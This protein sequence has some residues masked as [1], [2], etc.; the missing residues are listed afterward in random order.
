[1]LAGVTLITH[2][3]SSDVNSWVTA[4]AEAVRVRPGL[5]LDQ[6]RYR[7]DVTDVGHDGGPLTVT[8]TRLS[9]PAPASCTNSPEI[10]VLLNWSDVAGSL[11]F[12]GYHRST[13]DVAAA[14][15]EQLVVPNFLPDLPT[16]VAEL[17]LHLI[18]HSRGASLV[19]ELAKDLGAKGIWVD[20]VTTLDPHP[21]DGVREP[22]GGLNYGDAAMTGWRNV[23]FWD[24]YWR[25]QVSNPLDFTGETI[26]NVH[27]LQLNEAVL[28]SGGYSYEH[29]DV[30]L[31][32]HGTI[33]TS[34]GASDGDASVPAS[35]YGGQHPARD[36]SGYYYSRLL[37]GTRT[38]AGL[39]Q[40][41][42]GAAVR[43]DLNWAGA[44]WPNL[45]CT[46]LDVPDSHV[47]PGDLVRVAYWRQDYD[48][49]ATV[50]FYLDPD[51][52]PYNG[53]EIEAAQQSVSQTGAAPVAGALDIPT[54]SP[55][56]VLGRS[57][58]VSARLS[59]GP[60]TRYDYAPG[61]ITIT[62]RIVG[63]AADDSIRVAGSAVP[64]MAEVFVNNP[65][66]TPTYQADLSALTQWELVGGAGND[67]LVVDFSRRT[68]LPA[69]G[70]AA[71]GGANTTGDSLRITGTTGADRVRI[72]ATQ[73]LVTGESAIEWR[74]I[75]FFG[76]DLGE[77]ADHLVLDG[78][79][80]RTG[81]PNAISDNTAVTVNSGELDLGGATETVD[82]ITVIGG[83]VVN[84]TLWSNSRTVQGGVVSANLSGPGG[85]TMSG[86]GVVA[87]SGTNDY[88]D[89][90][91][92]LSG[93]L[94]VG[95]AVTLPAGRSVNIGA[96]ATVELAAGLCLASRFG[97]PVPAQPVA[98]SAS[99]QVTTTTAIGQPSGAIESVPVPVGQAKIE[100]ARN[101]A[102][103]LIERETR[104]DDVTSFFV[105]KDKDRR[106]LIDAAFRGGG[107]PDGRLAVIDIPP[108]GGEDHRPKRS[109]CEI[110]GLLL[111]TA[112]RA[113]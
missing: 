77:G 112:I 75:E 16:P 57:Y 23:V 26:T 34:A 104:E 49:V 93:T 56:I 59:D 106:E 28:T 37:G 39:S 1:L 2:G 94:L 20:Q 18:G 109:K 95:R 4:M 30:H 111:G 74:E 53:N 6:P 107:L 96:G 100:K 64:G 55:S 42:G 58:H 54:T 110:L 43:T 40:E 72:T 86:A 33:D 35:W 85:L 25:T 73:V 3:F 60:R 61:Q 89:G 22:F 82:A 12:G 44:V 15:A 31:W 27:D 102:L 97:S 62:G 66:P 81:S 87:L 101:R 69:G 99:M 5:T 50:T 92:V 63:T 32:Y 84:G 80:L 90:T 79:T 45:M 38:A 17:P 51:Q 14:V 67:L 48:S 76:F 113:E 108:A 41:L 10:V 7:I 9:G 21:V 11:P 88:T 103:D 70:L 71:V 19:G 91:T 13:V 98:L 36:A 8:G 68:P 65:G 83:R 78:A 47:A 29:S 52:N 46:R 105:M 24:N